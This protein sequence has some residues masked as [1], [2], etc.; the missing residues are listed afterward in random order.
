MAVGQEWDAVVDENFLFIYNPILEP[1]QTY[2]ITIDI[3]K[4]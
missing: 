4:K 1:N 2:T 3:D